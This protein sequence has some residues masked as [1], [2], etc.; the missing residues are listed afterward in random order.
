[1][2]SDC[3]EDSDSPQNAGEYYDEE[4]DDYDEEDDGS[5]DADPVEEDVDALIS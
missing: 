5:H 2:S 3:D 4:A 1:V